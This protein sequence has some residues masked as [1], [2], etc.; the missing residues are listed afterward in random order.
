[1]VK[2]VI[3][4]RTDLG[5]RKGKMVAQG[6]HASVKSVVKELVKDRKGEYTFH[7]NKAMEEWLS[8]VFTKICVG[9]GSEEELEEVHDAAWLAGV[10]VCKIVDNGTTEFHGVPTLTCLAVGP[11]RAEKIDAITGGL[12][13]L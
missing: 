10:P 8:G 5:M 11:D 6:A 9:V 2:Q 1:M 3:V 7:P 4:M 13:L 12:K